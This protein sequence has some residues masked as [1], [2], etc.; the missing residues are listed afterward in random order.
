MECEDKHWQRRAEDVFFTRVTV[1]LLKTLQR[2]HLLRFW[3]RRQLH[4]QH[5]PPRGDRRVQ[6]FA[7]SEP[8]RSRGESA[9][10]GA[11]AK[12]LRCLNA[13]GSGSNHAGHVTNSDHAPRERAQRAGERWRNDRSDWREERRENE[14]EQKTRWD[15]EMLH[16]A[17]RASITIL[18][19]P[20]P[21]DSRWNR[22]PH[23]P[24][25]PEAHHQHSFNRC[26]SRLFKRVGI[27][28]AA[29]VAFTSTDASS[30]MPAG[31]LF[32][33]NN[34]QLSLYRVEQD[35]TL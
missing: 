21:A 5:F 27:F 30:H 22:W 14:P 2:P 31:N 13:A 35:V 18:T 32:Q 4:K 16:R 33:H 19:G 6:S 28:L 12:T 24:H 20:C 9:A 1:N 25:I 3:P 10:R 17:F 23:L 8:A 7:F 11:S 34:L 15:L 26:C 29:F